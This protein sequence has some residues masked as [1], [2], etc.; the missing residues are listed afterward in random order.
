MSGSDIGRALFRLR[1][2]FAVAAAFG[3]AIAIAFAAS[4]GLR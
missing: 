2:S 4:T 1:N 3:A